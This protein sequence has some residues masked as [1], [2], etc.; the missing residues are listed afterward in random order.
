MAAKAKFELKLG[1][2]TREAFGTALLELGR[3]NKDIVV[4][5]ADLSKSTMT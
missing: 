5:D 4:V 2:A 3:E 1:P